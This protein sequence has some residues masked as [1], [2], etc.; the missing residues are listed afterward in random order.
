[1][2]PS[3]HYRRLGDGGVLFNRRTWKT[4]ILTPPAAIIYEALAEQSEGGAIPTQRAI[5]FLQRELSVDTD[6]NEIQQLL[7]MLQRLRVIA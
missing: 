2:K 1:M 4:H 3:L 7:T 6:S 5:E